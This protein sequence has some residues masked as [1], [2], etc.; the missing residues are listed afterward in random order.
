MGKSILPPRESSDAEEVAY[1]NRQSRGV[2]SHFK[3]RD[4]QIA[5]DNANEQA[6][7]TKS[8]LVDTPSFSTTSKKM[9]L[10]SGFIDKDSNEKLRIQP[11]FGIIHE[12]EEIKRYATTGTHQKKLTDSTTAGLTGQR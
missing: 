9:E 4:L 7:T 5:T 2:K 11:K 3:K 12:E 8:S 10:T 6:T 1:G